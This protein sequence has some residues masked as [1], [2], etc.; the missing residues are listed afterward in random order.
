MNNVSL[1]TGSR[2][3]GPT[4]QSAEDW[5]RV[6]SPQNLNGSPNPKFPH[7]GPRRVAF[8]VRP[9]TTLTSSGPNVI[10]SGTLWL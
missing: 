6:Q 8:S 2:A 10:H 4:D 3:L 5:A 1:G 7:P 9:W